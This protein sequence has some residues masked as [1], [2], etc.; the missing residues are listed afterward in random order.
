MMPQRRTVAVAVLVMF[1]GALAWLV[2]RQPAVT[3]DKQIF[4]PY[5]SW[6]LLVGAVPGDEVRSR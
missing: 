2:M 1:L 4:G 3:G 5:V 6:M